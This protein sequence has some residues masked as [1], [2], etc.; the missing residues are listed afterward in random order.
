MPIQPT[1]AQQ[2]DEHGY[3]FTACD[4][5]DNAFDAAGVLLVALS[6]I[7]RPGRANHLMSAGRSHANVSIPLAREV[8]RR[9]LVGTRARSPSSR[10]R[11]PGSGW[12]RR[13]S[14]LG[15][16]DAG[17]IC[18]AA[19][20]RRGTT[21]RVHRRPKATERTGRHGGAAA[22]PRPHGGGTAARR[23]S[24]HPPR[25]PRAASSR[26]TRR[27]AMP[28]R[29]G[30]R[31]LRRVPSRS[32]A[33][34]SSTVSL[35]STFSAAPP[36]GGAAGRHPRRL[37][38]GCRADRLGGGHVPARHRRHRDPSRAHAE[39]IEARGRFEELDAVP[40]GIAPCEYSCDPWRRRG[41][42][43]RSG[44][45]RLQLRCDVGPRRRGPPDDAS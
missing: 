41:R 20:C 13:R 45:P 11:G 16:A 29:Q 35:T 40:G 38:P 17:W 18:A 33:T 10:P 22:A 7:P 6:L 19:L 9:W 5:D 27:F 43:S 1:R 24:A 8:A 31:P 37:R 15:G 42:R 36:R 44:R 26:A 25:A 32:L 12:C 23:W 28:K 30:P 4:D 39:A 3:V 2:A 14:P 21:A 34:A